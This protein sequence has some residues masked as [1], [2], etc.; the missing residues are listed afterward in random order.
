[1]DNETKKLLNQIIDAVA[2][3]SLGLWF[4]VIDLFA[5]L[6]ILAIKL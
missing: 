5:L 6:I 2:I 4:I 1:M 3:G